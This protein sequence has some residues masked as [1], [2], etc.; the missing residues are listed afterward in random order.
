MRWADKLLL[1]LRSLFR[2]HEIEQELDAE[3][4][5]HLEQ[6]IEENL[7]AGLTPEEAR[8]TA[9]RSIGG[10]AQIKEECRDM[11][12]I[13][14]IAGILQ[15]LRYAARLF[16]RSPVFTITALVSLA[17]GIGA[18]SAI[19]TAADAILWKPLPVMHPESL[20][21]L[22]VTREKRHDLRKIPAAFA[23]ELQ[24]SSTVFSGVAG[25]VGDGLSFSLDGRAERIMG[26][27]VSNNFFTLLG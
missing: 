27:A 8:Y 5:F 14:M 16:R 18:N 10:L 22:T 12:R 26:E 7:T 15:D 25:A 11:R 20:V 4:R 6:Q 1:R 9:R 24:R 2:R 3:L 13:N 21:R 19:F 17:L 23:D